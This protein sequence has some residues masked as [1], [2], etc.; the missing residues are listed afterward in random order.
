M[1]TREFPLLKLHE[2][3]LRALAKELGPAGMIRFLQLYESGSGD[4]TKERHQWLD[5]VTPEE[6]NAGIRGIQ[7]KRRVR[8]RVKG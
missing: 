5:K 3:G 7:R 8:N 2:R 6:I 4:Y 1:K